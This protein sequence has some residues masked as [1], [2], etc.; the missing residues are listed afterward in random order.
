MKKVYLQ[1]EKKDSDEK[2][3]TPKIL[4]PI[5]NKKFNTE[6]QKCSNNHSFNYRKNL[7]VLT[8]EFGNQLQK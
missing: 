6:T 8:D 4:C 2:I 1:F 5:C 3:S 7:L